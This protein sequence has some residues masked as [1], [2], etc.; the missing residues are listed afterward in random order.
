MTALV[1]EFFAFAREREKI[2]LRREAGELF[3]WT[4]DPILQEF[5]FTNI[6]RKHDKTT[7]WIVDNW[8]KP[9]RGKGNL[10]AQF[11]NCALF[12]YTGTIDFAKALGWQEDWNPKKVM[13][14]ARE[15][16]N[17]GL[18]VFT[19]AYVIT[20]NAIR[21]PKE[22]VVCMSFLDPLWSRAEEI[23][24][25]GLETKSWEATAQA[26]MSCYG[27][28]G[29]GFMAKE[30]LQD[31]M[32]TDVLADCTDKDT[33]TPVGPGARR[34][35]NR[36]FGRDIRDRPKLDQQLKE[37]RLLKDLA[38]AGEWPS[39]WEPLG[40]HDIQ[41]ACCEFQKYKAI[42]ETGK[43]KRRYKPRKG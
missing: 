40:M 17:A 9:H 3:P 42:Q 23:A 33:W 29:S 30:T 21:L 19:S 20:N 38:D 26:L 7:K 32:F 5:R 39:E 28:G 12:R 27:F 34:G 11:F 16:L 10:K 2:R 41:F 4:E 25:I 1:K 31:V 35:L 13:S 36:V 18:P 8:Y 15:R 43:A 37:M 6:K 24:Q 22:E 14:L